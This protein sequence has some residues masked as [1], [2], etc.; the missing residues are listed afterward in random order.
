MTRDTIAISFD[1][2]HLAH[3]KQQMLN[4]SSQFSICLFLDSNQYPD[5]HGKYECLLAV[6]AAQTYSGASIMQL[7]DLQVYLNAQHDWLFGHL[8]YELKDVVEPSLCSN[9]SVIHGYPPFSFFVP[10]IVVL[11]PRGQASIRVESLTVPASTVADEILTQQEI[12]YDPLPRAAFETRLNKE[13]YL[14]K[15]A[16]L[17]K[18]IF[19]GDCYEITFCNESFSEGVSLS[20]LAVFTNLN[21]ASPA[22]FAAF[23]RQDHRYMMCASPERFLQKD[24]IRILSQPIKGT[25][26][27]GA[28]LEADERLKAALA[29]DEKEQ[30]ENVMIVD[31]VRNDLA[32]IAVKGSV[33][34]EEL[35]GLYSFPSVHQLISTVGATLRGGASF[36]DILAAT[37][38]MGSMTGAPKHRV[39]QLIEAYETARRE[40][41][42]G[43]VGY[44]T[45]A[46]DFDFNVIIRSLF[47]NETTAYFSYQTGGAITW[48]SVAEREWE[49][50]RLKAAAMEQLFK[51]ST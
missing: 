11:I 2:A 35:F 32:K 43:S 10:E 21:T 51:A 45:P 1:A 46:G 9:H 6:G 49:E 19:D 22:P 26:A 5:Q 31:L 12:K 30:A 40:L 25:A 3:I 34:V 50:T 48:G 36:V 29:A 37:F 7:A 42:S 47:Y 41:F 20:P 16:A 23:Y 13:A 15:I 17:R 38:P 14:E 44:I 18:H 39:M 28:N 8:T 33:E 24:G 4:W 27:R